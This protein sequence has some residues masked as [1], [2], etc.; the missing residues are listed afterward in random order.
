MAWLNELLFY[1]THLWLSCNW[2]D[3]FDSPVQKHHGTNKLVCFFSLKMQ[4]SMQKE[5]LTN[6]ILLYLSVYVK[7]KVLI[8]FCKLAHKESLQTNRS[9][10]FTILPELWIKWIKID[11]FTKWVVQIKQ[12]TLNAEVYT[13]ASYT[14][15]SVF[16][17]QILTPIKSK[18]RKYI[19]TTINKIS[20]LNI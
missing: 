15:S 8:H 12:E 13:R 11:W 14:D 17:Q 19:S 5:V 16:P 20:R 10:L 6:W 3:S 2:F 1:T 18:L 7:K 4:K 9:W